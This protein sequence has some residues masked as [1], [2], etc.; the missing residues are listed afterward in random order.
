[1]ACQASFST[2]LDRPTTEL[3][4]RLPREL[5]ARSRLAASAFI[6][7]ALGMWVLPSALATWLWR[8][9][10]LP[11][12]QLGP[13]LLVLGF[14]A[15]HGVHLTGWVGHEG[16]HFNLFQGRLLNAVVGVLVSSASVVFVQTGVA[17]EHVNHH[18][19]AN[20][21]ADPDLRLFGRQTTFWQRLLL[22][23]VRANRAFLR[24]AWRLVQGLPLEM[25]ER[26]LP[27]G[28]PTYERLALFNLVCCLGW[29]AVHTALFVSD[30][31]R[32]VCL[33]LMP[34]VFANLSSGLRPYLEHSSTDQGLWS[35]ARSRTHFLLA[36]L[37]FGNS[38]HLE[39]HLYPSVP[40]YRL[41]QVHRWLI[42]RGLVAPRHPSFEPALLGALG[43]ASGRHVYGELDSQLTRGPNP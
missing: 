42:R 2:A 7:F 1:M 17:I 16:F 41:W 33:T 15:G 20:S 11:P 23:R 5:Y 4:P 27:F 26:R 9:A 39:H 34:L 43:W 36:I 14:V 40:C 3:A 38:F 10:A 8:E 37:Y 18:R 21:E 32:G 30:P 22:T 19:F 35:C 24:A 12:W 28:R 31:R 29:L 13:V 6:A 25:D